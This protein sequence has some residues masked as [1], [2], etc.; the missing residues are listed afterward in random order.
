MAFPSALRGFPQDL[1]PTLFFIDVIGCALAPPVFW[2]AMNLWGVWAMIG[3][4]TISY[5]LV[6]IVLALRKHT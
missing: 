4:A 6:C 5:A 3:S 2:L 1:V